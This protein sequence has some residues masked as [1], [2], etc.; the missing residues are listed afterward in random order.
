MSVYLGMIYVTP[1]ESRLVMIQIFLVDKPTK[2]G[3][4]DVY[5][6]S[7]EISCATELQGNCNIWFSF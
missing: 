2:L 3:V 5:F 7:D 1:T 6:V 4:V